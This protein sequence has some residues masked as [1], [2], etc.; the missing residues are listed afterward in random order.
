MTMNKIRNLQKLVR[1]T[2]GAG[3][4]EYIILV[5]LVALFCIVAYTTFGEAVGAKVEEQAGEVEG[6]GN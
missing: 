1:D 5:G 6:I 4:V 3:F 2:R